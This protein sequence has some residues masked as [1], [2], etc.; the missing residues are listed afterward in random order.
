MQCT[1]TRND[2]ILHGSHLTPCRCVGPVSATQRLHLHQT[3]HVQ[4]QLGEE[5]P[6]AAANW[7]QMVGSIATNEYCWILSRSHH[8]ASE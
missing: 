4:A 2:M 1:M 8:A 7:V 3:W 6:E 5:P